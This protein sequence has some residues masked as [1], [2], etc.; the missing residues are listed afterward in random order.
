MSNLL[1][2]TPRYMGLLAALILAGALLPGCNTIRRYL[3]WGRT[4]SEPDPGSPE[5]VVQIVLRAGLELD[6]SK[7][8]KT[9]LDQLHSQER[10]AAGS[11]V[12]CKRTYWP[13]FRRKVRFFSPDPTVPTYELIY[14][15]ESPD[16]ISIKMFVRSSA[17]DTPTPIMVKQDAMEGNVWKLAHCSI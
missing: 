16:K 15:E 11:V 4:I 2:P 7:A 10:T 9:F 6:E 5:A 1:R 13:A 12:T 3:G 14:V 8:W 17:S